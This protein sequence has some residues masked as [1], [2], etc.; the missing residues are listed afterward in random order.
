MGITIKHVRDCRITIE[1]VHEIF[2]HNTSIRNNISIRNITFI[3]N[4]FRHKDIHLPTSI[5]TSCFNHKQRR[6][7]ILMANKKL[8][9]RNLQLILPTTYR[10]GSLSTWG[11]CVLDEIYHREII[12]TLC[13]PYNPPPPQE[14]VEIIPQD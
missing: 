8:I 2:Y 6:G 11:L 3:E 10:V 9:V 13:H 12:K 14:P 7:E 5:L 4:I 1:S